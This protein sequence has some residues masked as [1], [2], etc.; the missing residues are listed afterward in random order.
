MSMSVVF[1]AIMPHPPILIPEIGGKRIKDAA[2]SAKALKEIVNRLKTKQFDSVIVITPH[3][4]VSY[5]CL[6]VYS[7]PVFDGDFS[8]F[9]A[10]KLSFHFKGDVELALAIVKDNPNLTARNTETFLD[11]GLLVPLYYITNGGINKPILPVA[12][13]LFSLKQL[14]ECGQM[15]ARAAQ[16][17][18]RRIAVIASAD[19]SHRLTNDAPSGYHSEGKRFDETL[20]S[21][22][23]KYDVNGIL[24]FPQKLA[25]IAGQDALWSI[26]ILLGAID[27]LNFKQEVLS[28]EG[29]FGV[30][31]MV[32]KFE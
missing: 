20:V 5:V 12:V 23:E 28:Y 15:I 25:N 31:Y 7:S 30:G 22:V 32:A 17:I 27:G 3:G 19:M 21:L 29:P 26:A 11:H 1:G 16:K 10:P 8:S 13:A 2:S 9:G 18:G 4:N 24:N 14:F 6:P